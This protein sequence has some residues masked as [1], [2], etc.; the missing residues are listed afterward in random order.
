MRFSLRWVPRIIHKS[1]DSTLETLPALLILAWA[2]LLLIWLFVSA[3][4]VSW[5][6]KTV[7]VPVAT[8]ICLTD[9]K[10]C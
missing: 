4:P 8:R 7:G 6:A 3:M 9:V 2:P 5:P 10:K 1:M